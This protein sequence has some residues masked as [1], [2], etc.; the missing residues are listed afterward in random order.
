M[1]KLEEF[2]DF[3]RRNMYLKAAVD[4]R[5]LTWQ[6]VY[7]LY[8]LFGE[9]AE[10]FERIRQSMEPKPEE[11]QVPP[12]SAGTA[13][14]A[15]TY[16]ILSILSSIDYN[17]VS[18]TIDQLQKILGVVKD[19]SHTEEPAENKSRKIFKRFND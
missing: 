7:E 9:N 18:N 5:L 15:S 14:T 2:K 10:E 8:D 1:H 4:A 3:V 12:Q 11:A 16:D 13:S 6:K 19:F 17:K